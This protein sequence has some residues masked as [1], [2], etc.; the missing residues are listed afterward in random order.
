MLDQATGDPVARPA[1]AAYPLDHPTPDAAEVSPDRLWA[2]IGDAARAAIAAAGRPV[3]GVGLTGMTPA[4]SVSI[5]DSSDTPLSP[6]WTH[7]DRRA[8]PQAHKAQDEVGDEFLRTVGTRPLP[9]RHVGP[10]LRPP[11]RRRPGA[12]GRVRHYLHALGWVAFRLTES[13]P[14]TRPTPAS[15]GC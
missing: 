13:G 1:K 2:A 3:D 12:A 14:S 10:L 5:L 8:R 7:L 15:P 4:V 6:I 9:G 11:T